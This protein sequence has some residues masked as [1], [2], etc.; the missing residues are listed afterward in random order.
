ME[1]V[2]APAAARQRVTMTRQRIDVLHRDAMAAVREVL[3]L[4]PA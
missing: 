4:Q 2:S 1:I 3:K